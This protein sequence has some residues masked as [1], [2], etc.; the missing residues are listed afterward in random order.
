MGTLR[1]GSGVGNKM[2]GQEGD[3]A[4]GDGRE[5]QDLWV[6]MGMSSIPMQVSKNNSIGLKLV[7]FPGHVT[8][9]TLI[10]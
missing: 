10:F 5:G 1:A 4:C 2:V 6:G 3:R 7:K 9:S 8:L